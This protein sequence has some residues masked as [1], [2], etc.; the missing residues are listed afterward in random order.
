MEKNEEIF[1]VTEEFQRLNPFTQEVIR[2]I[3]SIPYGKVQTYGGIARFAGNPRGARQV[4]RILHSLSKKYGLPWHRVVNSKGE[5]SL[6]DGREEQKKALE[7]EGITF[8]SENKVNL[9]H[10]LWEP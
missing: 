4:A 8:T 5:I 1:W 2:L 3:K 7:I 6:I 10:Y 9:K